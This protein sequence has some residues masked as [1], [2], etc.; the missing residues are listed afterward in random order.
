[1]G[2]TKELAEA[3]RADGHTVHSFTS[4]AVKNGWKLTEYPYLKANG[5]VHFKMV[6]QDKPDGKMILPFLPDGTCAYPKG[7]RSLYN[8]PA[9]IRKGSGDKVVIVEGEK[10]AEAAKRVFPDCVVTTWAGGG[11]SIKSTD[12]EPLKNT[13]VLLIADTDESG[14]KAMQKVFLKL[15]TKPLYCSVKIYCKEGEDKTD[16]ADWI[17]DKNEAEYTFIRAQIE[18]G[19]KDNPPGVGGVFLEATARTLKAAFDAMGYEYRYNLRSQRVEIRLPPRRGREVSAMEREWRDWEELNDLKEAKRF[20]EVEKNFWIAQPEGERKRFRVPLNMRKVWLYEIVHDL[21]VD[22]FSD[23]LM[24][25]PEWDNVKRIDT[26]LMD[27]F[28][29]EDNALNRWASRFIFQGAVERA[30]SPGCKLDEMPVLIGKQGSGKSTFLREIL[31]SPRLFSDTLRWDGTPQQRVESTLGFAI[32]EASEMVGISRAELAGLKSYLSRQNDEGVRLPYR[33]NPESLPRRCIFVGTSNETEALPND[34]TG[35]RRFLAIQ[36][37]SGSY[38]K[39]VEYARTNK[40]QLWAE[41]SCY[42]Q[43]GRN[44]HLPNELKNEQAQ[45]NADFRSSDEYL[46][47]MVSNL[48]PS[49]Y[50]L[51]MAEIFT[52]LMAEGK[53]ISTKRMTV[54]LQNKGWTRRRSSGKKLWCSPEG[55]EPT[56]KP[57]ERSE[58]DVVPF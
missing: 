1:M 44:A 16:I 9:I 19:A 30:F 41:A 52:I 39:V 35:N 40:E 2:R 53:R 50:G 36:C 26:A 37:P 33:R 11:S 32:V 58:G 18:N 8:L 31:P 13:T 17:E 57:G 21:Q 7:K 43:I 24:T 14:R 20:G 56:L 29:V 10:C 48:E 28:G 22:P 49:K 34:P 27:V 5:I 6:R 55:W 47:E 42:A 12:W 51:T 45:R 15:K 4:Q 38:N 25:L 23:W 46:E 54:A 3:E